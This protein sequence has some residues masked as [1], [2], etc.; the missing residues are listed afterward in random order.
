MK[1]KNPISHLNLGRKVTDLTKVYLMYFYCGVFDKKSLI[2]FFYV[3]LSVY[4]NVTQT[5]HHAQ[6]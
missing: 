6:I 1:K 3:W 2:Y 4:M 5:F